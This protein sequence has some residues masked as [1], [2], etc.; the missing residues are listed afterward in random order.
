MLYYPLS[1][2][3]GEIVSATVIE[4]NV[5]AFAS[6]DATD[7]RTN[8]SRSTGYERAFSFKQQAQ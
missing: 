3:L 7:G 8:T 5:R 4:R 1:R 6:Q 2:L